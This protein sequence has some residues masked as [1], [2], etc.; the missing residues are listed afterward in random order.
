MPQE[1]SSANCENCQCNN[2][3]IK[4]KRFDDSNFN[5]CICVSPDSDFAEE[6]LK[7]LGYFVITEY[8]ENEQNNL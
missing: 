2:T 6:A 5:L 8:Y 3:K 4:I 7:R 1:N